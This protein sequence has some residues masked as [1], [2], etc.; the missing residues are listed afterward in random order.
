MV[1]EG[2]SNFFSFSSFVAFS[3]EP[4]NYVDVTSP[5]LE[6]KKCGKGSYS[7]GGGVRFTNWDQ[8]PMGF[9]S[10]SSDL[11]YHGY[12]YDSEYVGEEQGVNCSQ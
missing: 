12:G 8:L 9:E 7:V 1:D 4:G 11:S 3:C 2:D 5:T 10:R 6:C